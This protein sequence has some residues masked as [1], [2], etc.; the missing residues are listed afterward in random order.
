MRIQGQA[1]QA[2][3]T[4]KQYIIVKKEDNIFKSS[5]S[6]SDDLFEFGVHADRNMEQLGLLSAKLNPSQLDALRQAD[7]TVVEDK[8]IQLDLPHERNDLT[9]LL[10]ANGAGIEDL[11]KLIPGEDQSI[12]EKYAAAKAKNKEYSGRAALE[13]PRY[14]SDLAQTY[15][16]KGVGIAVLD[17]GVY[18]HPDL[19]DRLVASVDFAYQRPMPYDNGGHGTHVATIAAGDGSSSENGIYRGQAPKADVLNLKVLGDRGGKTSD[20][21]AAIDWAI[22]NKDKYNIRVMNLSLGHTASGKWEDDPLCVATS[23]AWDAGIFVVAAAGN[24][25]PD[26]STMSAPGSNPE[27]LTVGALDDHNTKSVADDN[28]AGFSSRGPTPDG[29]VKPDIL[30]P[31]VAIMAG[32]SPGSD[33][34]SS[35]AR[36]SSMYQTMNYWSG[37]YEAFKE[38]PNEM[39]A[40]LGIPSQYASLMKMSEPIFDKVMGTLKESLNQAHSEDSGYYVAI[41]GTS[42]ATPMVAGIAAKAFEAN[43]DLTN[44]QLKAIMM[45]T[46]NPLTENRKV[47]V[48]G[49]DGQELV[50]VTGDAITTETEVPV[51]AHDQGAGVIDVD[52]VLEKAIALREEEAHIAG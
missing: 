36:R 9:A 27:I 11:A 29:L 18:P 13:E 16:G 23:K 51:S 33:V 2:A 25:G 38:M 41:S 17:T 10:E 4:K 1:A 37:Q 3:T 28:V 43:P 34:E 8:T 42:M 45:D 6:S 52:A 15:Q 49:V 35:A 14:N 20:I 39:I 40:S 26:P 47:E 30:A 44:D 48:K 46:A 50:S 21:L 12:T 31:G 5:Q 24:S 32:N 19:G 22:E 7:Y